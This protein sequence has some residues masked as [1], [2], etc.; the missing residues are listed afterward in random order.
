[1]H[2]FTP[3]GP[4][5]PQAALI[6]NVVQSPY[7]FSIFYFDSIAVR[8]NSFIF[9]AAIFFSLGML[10]ILRPHNRGEVHRN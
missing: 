1:M 4:P 8:S 7:V 5:V 10:L 9:E 3:Y 6:I 2:Y